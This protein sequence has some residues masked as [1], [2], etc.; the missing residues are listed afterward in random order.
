MET[1]DIY[2]QDSADKRK[3]SLLSLLLFFLLLIGLVIPIFS[4][5]IPPPELEGVLISFGQP[6]VG[7]GND[8][9]DVQQEDPSQKTSS[10][11]AAPTEQEEKKAA[12]PASAPAAKKEVITSV[13]EKE[14]VQPKPTKSD[15]Q[16]AEERRQ[17]EAAEQARRE[18]AER[19]A[20]AKA[21][22]ERQAKYEASKKQFGDFLSGAGKGNTNAVGNQGD[23][24]G[25]PNAAILT[26]ITTGSGRI[27]GG[28]ANRGLE[29][30]PEIKDNSQKA[31]KVVMKVCVDSNGKVREAT[32]TQRGSTTV[33]GEL[34]EK[35]KRAAFRYKFSSSDVEEQCGT[36]TFDFKLE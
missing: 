22:A 7:S 8:R 26:G 18:E 3:S 35:A 4:Y 2:A 34:R 10:A 11:A 19:A 15:Q 30:E 24:E 28:L 17:Q 23:P 12:P 36:I 33:D 16:L 5:Q 27:G 25:D 32:F 1:V 9:P 31:G 6:D 14:V 21:E 29:Y 13:I 20:K